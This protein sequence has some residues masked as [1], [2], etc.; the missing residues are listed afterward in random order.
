MNNN[1]F[2]N[3]LITNSEKKSPTKLIK[4][5]NFNFFLPIKVNFME[6]LSGAKYLHFL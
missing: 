1:K 5:V 6:N 3:N 4:N 2:S